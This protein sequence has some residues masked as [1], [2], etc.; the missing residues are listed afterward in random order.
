MGAQRGGAL[1]AAL[2]TLAVLA[3]V[4]GTAQ[5]ATWNVSKV[6][7]STLNV[8]HVPPDKVCTTPG[9]CVPTN[10]TVP[11][12]SIWYWCGFYA[13]H[14]TRY[15]TLSFN[16][17]V[18][19]TAVLMRQ[20][21]L[22]GCAIPGLTASGTCPV[23]PESTCTAAKCN[24]RTFGLA[25]PDPICLLLVNNKASS[26]VVSL[27]INNYY[28]S[29]RYYG[30]VFSIL[31][32][33][34]GSLYILG[35]VGRQL[36]VGI[37]TPPGHK[38]GAHAGHKAAEHDG[39]GAAAGGGPTSPTAAAALAQPLNPAGEGVAVPINGG[40]QAGVGAASS[41]VQELFSVFGIGSSQQ[42]QQ[43]SSKQP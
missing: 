4:S 36:Y 18:N 25:F 1:T 20:H 40:G 19:V 8:S 16:A 2:L 31:L 30:T 3:A 12:N 41:K 33:I 22:T 34:L 11:G 15:Q 42:Q 17:K 37:I 6:V 23:I 7:K 24:L 29:P 13:T 27:R 21:E 14:R 5:A 39:L 10:V 9:I 26:T 32:L 35:T 38:P 43:H 28:D